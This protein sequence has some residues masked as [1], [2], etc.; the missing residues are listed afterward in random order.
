[1]TLIDALERAARSP[2]GVHFIDRKEQGKFVPYEHIYARARSVA[3]GLKSLG[4]SPGDRVA[5]VIPTDVAFYEAFFGALVA[6]MVPVP[7][8]P[9]VRL[10]RLDE[11]H[12]RTEGMLRACGASVL[13]TDSRIGRLLGTTLTSAELPFGA[14]SVSAL[15]GKV[16]APPAIGED[17]VAMI[18]FSSGTT[19]DPKPVS[20]THRNVCANIRSITAAIISA[21]PE[22]PRFSHLPVS[23]L[24]LYHDMG[25]VGCV[26]AALAHP[27]DLVL[28]P[29]E[30]FVARPEVWLRTISRYR[31]TVSAAPNFAYGLCADR[32][33]ESELNN[34]DLS[35][36]VIALNGAEAVQ[37]RTMERFASRF[38]RC[39]FSKRALTPVY[40]LA[41]AAL[42]V[43]FSDLKQSYRM[44]QFDRDRLTRDGV[45]TPT[46]EEG[47][48]LVSVGK[49]LT[50]GKIRITN[51]RGLALAEDRVGRVQVKGPSVMAGYFGDDNQTQK[52]LHGGWLDTGDLGFIHDGELYLYG[53]AKDVIILR[54]RNYSP[55]DV[56][57]SA[58]GIEGVRV[59]CTAAVGIVPSGGEAEEILM[60]V[61]R[62]KGYRDS[63]AHLAEQVSRHI[64][65]TTGLAPVHAL[66]L[67]PG[68]LPRT[69]S[70]KIRRSEA[71]KRFLAGTLV[72]PK[73]VSPLRLAG[74]VAI[75]QMKLLRA[76][77]GV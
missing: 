3:G 33:R 54:G 15:S 5:I 44:V 68:T 74:E 26:L 69:S 2:R 64:T 56:E 75:S 36:W 17:R 42:A 27:S 71:R 8:Y 23:W 60:L 58:D 25:L 19:V 29:P 32:I 67:A 16:A 43:T 49:P 18:Q 59:G 34:L 50:H 65:A 53:R 12:R 46:S 7:L 40:G 57:Q 55:H 37:H 30:L 13:L 61:E 14:H 4:L 10:G 62:A 48:P 76:R 11:Y 22:T 31:G 41:E 73:R 70:G 51:D 6:D 66:I 63:D 45:A 52:A 1:M 72:P 20:L 9:P 38:S 21:H 28:I 35:S 77:Y 24:P 47:Q 39:G